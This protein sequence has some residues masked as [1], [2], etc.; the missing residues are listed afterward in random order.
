MGKRLRPRQSKKLLDPY[1]VGFTDGLASLKE[2]VAIARQEGMAAGRR[3]AELD[4]NI[5]KNAT[6][7]RLWG[8]LDAVEGLSD[9][10]LQIILRAHLSHL[11][12]RYCDSYGQENFSTVGFSLWALHNEEWKDILSHNGRDKSNAVTRRLQEHY[13]GVT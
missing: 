13:N 5:A 11:V 9:L 1:A 7:L 4:R 3:A 10:Q 2:T 8:E 6:A 12:T